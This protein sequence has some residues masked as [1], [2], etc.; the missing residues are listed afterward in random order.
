MI[1]S[2]LN[3]S[4]LKLSALKLNNFYNN[5]CGAGGAGGAGGAVAGVLVCCS[6]CNV[7]IQDLAMFQCNKSSLQSKRTS[8]YI[9]NYQ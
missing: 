9:S 7:I 4:A 3:L 1:L 2:A 8:L 5:T 6:S